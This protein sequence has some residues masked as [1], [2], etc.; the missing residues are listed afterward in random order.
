MKNT[1]KILLVSLLLLNFGSIKATHI[2]GGE[3]YYDCLGDG[4]FKITVRIYRDC[5]LGQAPFDDPLTVS[6]YDAQGNLFTNL[7]LF[8]PIIT[9]ILPGSINPCYQGDAAVCVEEAFYTDDINL[10]FSP[11]GYTLVYQRCCRNNSILNIFDPGDT[12]AT[13]TISIPPSAWTEC[14]SSPRYSQ[15]P[16]IVLC[17]NDPL[18]FDHSATDP[19]GD[20]LVYSFCDPFEG[21]SADLPMPVPSAAPPF[22]FANFIPPYSANYPLASNPAVVVNP[23][24]GQL[25]GEPTLLGQFVVAV[26][27][28]EYRNGVLLSVNKR[29]FQFNIVQCSGSSIAEFEA[30]IVELEGGIIPCNGLSVN[31]LNL[32]QNASFYQWDFGVPGIT[33]DVSTLV[34]PVYAFPDTGV[35]RVSLIANPGYSCADSTFLIITVFHAIDAQVSQQDGQCITSNSFDFI[36]QGEFQSYADFYWEFEGPC[37]IANSTLQNPTGIVWS[38]PGT[39]KVKLRISDPNCENYDSILVT[40]YPVLEVDFNVNEEII[41]VP[42][43]VLFNNNS[44]VSPGAYFYWTF[45]DGGFS[46]EESPVHLYDTPGNYDVSLTVANTVGCIDTFTVLF[47][48]YIRA[49]PRPDAGL[50]ASP[51][52]AS[53]LSP[54]ITFTDLSLGEIGSWLEL[55]DGQSSDNVNITYTYQDTGYYSPRIIAVNEQN[56][57]DTATIKI[58]IK[59]VYNVYVPNSFTPNED[60]VNDFFNAKGEGI[61]TFLMIIFDRWGDE[62]FTT[63]SLDISWDG[64]ANSGKKISPSGVYNYKIWIRNVLSEEKSLQGNVTLYR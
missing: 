21:A 57:Y 52:E 1:I 49:K 30:P 41:C 54:Y 38:E 46:Y 22:G 15:F 64:R 53:I 3:I 37:N 20:S 14:N 5:L 24:T 25:T 55:G 16:P 60:G 7:E 50:D 39:Y 61:K 23:I 31:F 47:E 8:N 17:I 2:I 44:I 4:D 62:V 19:D 48:D 28:F 45:G 32:S 18:I 13:Y 56:C 26:C 43:E 12:G 6:I 27:V 9:N 10:P 63:T 33:S 11:G 29:D 58:R 34:D 42:R 36:A 40:V 59:P 35:Y 51:R